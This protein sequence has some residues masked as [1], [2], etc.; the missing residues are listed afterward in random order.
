M[1]S[2]TYTNLAKPVMKSK[3]YQDKISAPFQLTFDFIIIPYK[4]RLAINCTFSAPTF[5]PTIKEGMVG[6]NTHAL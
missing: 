3:G 4:G 1:M 5:S 6:A 2:L